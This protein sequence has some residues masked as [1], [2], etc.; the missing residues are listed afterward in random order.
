MRLSVYQ[1][2]GAKHDTEDCIRAYLVLENIQKKHFV[3]FVM[4]TDFLAF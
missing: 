2:R 1:H 4:A 3:H